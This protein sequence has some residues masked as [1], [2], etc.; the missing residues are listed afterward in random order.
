MG[1]LQLL[2]LF[3]SLTLSLPPQ[4][5]FKPR[6]WGTFWGS[7]GAL[8]ETMG[9]TEASTMTDQS[10]LHHRAM[11]QCSAANRIPMSQMT[12]VTG[13]ASFKVEMMMPQVKSH[14]LALTAL[15]PLT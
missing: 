5:E 7:D 2:Y 12:L 1:D 15:C 11:G 4:V 9:G 13:S 14:H 6:V 10:W 8:W 3:L